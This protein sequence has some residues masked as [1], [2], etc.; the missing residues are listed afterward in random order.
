MCFS[1][2]FQFVVYAALSKVSAS[3]SIFK[4]LFSNFKFLFSVFKFH[5]FSIL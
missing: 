4:F 3:A 2:V 1:S 5:I